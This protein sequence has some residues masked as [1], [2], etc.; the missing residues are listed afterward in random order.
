MTE[1]Q[2][3]TN[4]NQVRLADLKEKKPVELLGIAEEHEIENASTLRKQELL[5]AIL[6]RLAEKDI[7]IINSTHN[8][9]IFDY[10]LEIKIHLDGVERKIL[11]H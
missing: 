2:K 10:D 11:A 7:T 4:S 6:K 8:K 5:F 3:N 1:K 9:E